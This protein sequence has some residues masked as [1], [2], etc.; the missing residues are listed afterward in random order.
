MR[1][2]RAGQRAR[3][4]SIFAACDAATMTTD[5]ADLTS[6]YS[7]SFAVSRLVAGIGTTPA[8]MQPTMT[9]YHCAIRGSIT[10]AKAPRGTPYLRNMLAVRF[11]A[12]LNAEKRYRSTRSALRSTA[13]KAVASSAT[14]QASTISKPKLKCSGNRISWLPGCEVC[15]RMRFTASTASPLGGMQQV[16]RFRSYVGSR[17]APSR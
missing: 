17:L 11:D 13:T 12:R 5:A 6:R 2:S 8:L 16:G 1:C 15:S 14:P 7:M 4:A 9:S 10:S 3:T